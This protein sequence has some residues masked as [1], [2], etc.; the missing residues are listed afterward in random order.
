MSK[1]RQSALESVPIHVPEAIMN[2]IPAQEIERCGISAVEFAQ[3][4]ARAQNGRV[5]AVEPHIDVLPLA[6]NCAA[7][8][9]RWRKPTSCRD[10]S[11]IEDFRSYPAKCCRKRS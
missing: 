2:S 11:R 10:W 9:R 4:L 1:G 7:R 3:H 6:W 5:L 8:T